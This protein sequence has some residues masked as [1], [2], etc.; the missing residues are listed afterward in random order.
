M[1]VSG[2]AEA[3]S[4]ANGFGLFGGVVRYSMTAKSIVDG[5][6]YDSSGVGVTLGLDYQFS[7]NDN[8]SINPF[9]MS[10]SENPSGHL[11]GYNVDRV[12]HG[13]LGV[14][15]R[16]WMQDQI[17]IGADIGLYS[18]GYN[19]RDDYTRASGDGYGLAVGWESK[20]SGLIASVRY[21]RATVGYSNVDVELSGIRLHVGYRWK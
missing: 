21:D 15:G 5:S 3:E 10:T 1:L 11:A 2:H 7:L 19:I 17:F 20:I 16:Y 6:S 8:I 14:Q 12:G 13:I 4:P 18:E 9:A